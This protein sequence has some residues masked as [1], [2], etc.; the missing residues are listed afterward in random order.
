MQEGTL[1][2][3]A[4]HNFYNPENHPYMPG[5]FKG[6]KFILEEQGFLEQGNF[7]G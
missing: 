7:M 3:G 2:N 5:W 4:P 6:M 1:P